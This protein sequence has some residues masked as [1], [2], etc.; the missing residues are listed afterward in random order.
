MACNVSECWDFHFLVWPLQL[1]LFI[2]STSIIQ[3]SNYS[4]IQLF[5]FNYSIIQLFNYSIIPPQLFNYPIIQLVNY[6]PF[7][8]DVFLIYPRLSFMK[9]LFRF[10]FF[11]VTAL[12]HGPTLPAS[13]ST[14]PLTSVSRVRIN[15]TGAFLIIHYMPRVHDATLAPSF[16]RPPPRTIVPLCPCALFHPVASTSLPPHISRLFS[17]SPLYNVH[18]RPLVTISFPVSLV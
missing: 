11:F 15:T 9:T 12:T 13:A 18:K 8:Q 6:Y 17:Y 4:I 7:I 10:L 3:L 14:S 16:P 5:L 1:F 2:Y